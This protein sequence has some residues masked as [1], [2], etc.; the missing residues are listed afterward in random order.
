NVQVLKGIP[1]DEFMGTMGFFAA[2]LSLNCTDCH[3]KAANDDWARYADDTPLKQ[4]ARKMVLMVRTINQANFGG[5][6]EVTCYTCHRSSNRPKIVPSL[7][8]Q[9]GSPPEDPNEVESRGV[10]LTRNAP[11]VDQVLDKYIQAL[12]G[13]QRLARLTSFVAK[14]TYSGYDTSDDKVPVEV[15]A[16]AP[17][18]RTTVL[19]APVGDGVTKNGT[20]T[21]DGRDGW[22]NAANTLVPML[23]LTGGNLDG[24]RVDAAL[25]FPGGIKQALSDWRDGFPATSIDGRDVEVVQGTSGKSTVKLYFDKQSGLLVRQVRYAQTIVGPNPTQIDYS[26]YREVAGVKLPFNWVVTW[27]D[28]QSKFEM[29]QVQPNAAIDAARFAKPA[30]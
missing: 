5:K 27:T 9:Y 29:S 7:A 22:I 14:G 17:N 19:H 30:P 1:M 15:Y 24:A 2:A 12:G 21:F 26:D 28:G 16:K 23:T 10:A 3:V 6:T 25:S 4:T 13:A 8:E 18:Q 11:S 20:T